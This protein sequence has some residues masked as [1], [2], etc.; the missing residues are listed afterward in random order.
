MAFSSELINALDKLLNEN[1]SFDDINQKA[2]EI[3]KKYRANDN[4]GIRLVTKSN[5][6]IAYALSRMPATYESVASVIE[7]IF[8]LN[9]FEINTVL[10]VGAGTGAG[11]WAVFDKL[12]PKN[13][14]CLEREQ[15]MINIGKKLMCNSELEKIVNW[16][17]F[18]VLKDQLDNKYDLVII[19]YMINELPKEHIQ[20]VLEKI[21]NATNEVLI[22]IEPGTPKGFSNILEIRKKLI[23]EKANLIAP[24][25][26]ELECPIGKNDWCNF[27]CRIQ[28]SKVHKM[29]KD[30]QSPFEDEKF[31]YVAFSRKKVYKVNNRILR[32]PIINKVFSEYKICTKD[33]IKNVKI[34]KK[35]G[36]LYK[37]AKKKS[38]GDSLNLNN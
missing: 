30:G 16:K 3:S 8:E 34:S 33:G 37:E 36:I 2:K 32:H 22:I 24:C 23:N 14:L 11:T 28:R 25:S 12:G 35:N 20:K 1:V 7:K 4:N 6:A 9:D 27:S 31:S 15:E 38:T 21:W 19:S 5:E 26:H 18:D 29:L 13:F 17:Q 10:D